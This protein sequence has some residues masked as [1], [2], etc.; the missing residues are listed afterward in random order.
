MVDHPATIS[1]S[2]LCIALWQYSSD[3]GWNEY[4]SC[5]CWADLAGIGA[6][7]PNWP[8]LCIAARSKSPPLHALLDWTGRRGYL[9]FRTGTAP[10]TFRP[11]IG[12]EE[13]P[14]EH[15]VDSRF[16]VL[17]IPLASF[18]TLALGCGLFAGRGRIPFL[19][20][21]HSIALFLMFRCLLHGRAYATLIRLDTTLRTSPSFSAIFSMVVMGYKVGASRGSVEAW[22][23]FFVINQP[24]STLR[25]EMPNT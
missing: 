10:F 9:L 4:Q 20:W 15:I 21:T 11:D 22:V 18:L 8:L 19:H 6:E 5:A 14:G 25:K 16:S 17:M 13:S 1:H 23:G 3:G 12:I 7:G 2:R 24:T